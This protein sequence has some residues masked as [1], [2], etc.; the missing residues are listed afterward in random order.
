MRHLL[1][2]LVLVVAIG[3]RGEGAYP[4]RE[5][6]IVVHAAPG[7]ISDAVTRHVARGLQEEIGVP[8][9]AENRPGAAGSVA[10][11]Y[12]ARSR[13]DGYTIG[14]APV[15][16]AITHH[17]GYTTVGPADFDFLM[18]HTRAPAVLA[19][20]SEAPWPNLQA[21]IAAARDQPR[22]LNMATSG[23]G[24]I[25][26]LAGVGFAREAGISFN[27]VPFPGSG[28]AVTALLGGHADAVIAGPAEVQAH[29]DA[30]TLR[31]LGVMAGERSEIFPEIPTF[32]EQ[33]L[34]LEFTAWGGFLAP[35]GLPADRRDLLVAALRRVLES[36][37][38][39]RFARERGLEIDVMDAT[40]FAQFVRQEDELFARLVKEAG[41]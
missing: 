17:L 29:V 8:I 28:P 3:C 33:G 34:A 23:T 15:D 32:E 38:F 26:H 4:D 40:A 27:Y 24:S 1:V 41:L 7:G 12:V 37:D 30:G 39:R 19:V 31:M 25:W 11:S 5:I 36:D 6:R 20:R 35:D 21:F 18:L 2:V 14:Y 22:P 10:F 9:V 13:P 16:L